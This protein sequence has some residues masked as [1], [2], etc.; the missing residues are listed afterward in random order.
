MSS[1]HSTV[2]ERAWIKSV[3]CT[4]ER[5]G[6]MLLL[7]LRRRLHQAGMA[8]A[9]PLLLQL[10]QHPHKVAPSARPT[11]NA[12]LHSMLLRCA[13]LD[14]MR[15]CRLRTHIR[16]HPESTAGMWTWSGW[17][18]HRSTMLHA[19]FHVLNMQGRC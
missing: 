6:E 4:Q 3:L 7:Q 1:V 19:S 13:A 2:P 14:K 18:C 15:A 12:C 16:S 10:L 5:A 9:Q 8:E 17:R 11:D